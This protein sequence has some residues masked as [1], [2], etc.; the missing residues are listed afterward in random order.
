MSL[1]RLRKKIKREW[2]AGLSKLYVNHINSDYLGM[3][4]K[5]P[6][7]HGMKNGGYILPAE[8]WMSDCLHTFTDTKPGCIIDI[9]VNIGL[10]LVKLR[11]I[12]ESVNYYGIDANPAC[13]FYTQE[14]IRL[15]KFKN[16]KLFT[17]ALS[18]QNGVSTFYASKLGDD[19]GSLVKEH[20]QNNNMAY[21]FSTMTLAGD[22]FINTLKLDEDIST[23]KIDVEEAEIYVLRGLEKTIETYSPY[24]Y[25]EILFT[26]TQIQDDRAMQIC[27]FIQDKNYSILGIKRN[28]K[29]LE[30]IRDITEVGKEYEQEYAFVPTDYL[31]KFMS[32]IRRNSSGVQ[33]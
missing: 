12:S 4:L 20:Q 16:A 3:D 22:S 23:I 14:L 15:N 9:G 32:S 11:V 1:D 25:C 6:L 29:F 10:Y 13:T 28:T 31:D 19:T 2:V 26:Q 17:L 18:D 21:S 27:K 7:I 33:V 30:V 8:M 5:V 24:I